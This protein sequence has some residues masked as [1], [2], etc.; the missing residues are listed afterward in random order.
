MK[1]NILTTVL[2][3]SLFVFVGSPSLFGQSASA[4]DEILAQESLTYGAAS[5]LLLSAIGEVG[6]DADFREAGEMM[7]EM[8]PL[9]GERS[10][11]EPLDLG[12]YSFLLMQVFDRSGGLMYSILPGPRYAVREL[13]FLEIVQGDTYPNAD[14]SG[15]RAVRILERFLQVTGETGGGEV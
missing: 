4:M 8:E 2:V 9:F 1:K 3:L 14:L 11:E 7:A 5:Y 10:S 15:E 6:D 13:A 12:E